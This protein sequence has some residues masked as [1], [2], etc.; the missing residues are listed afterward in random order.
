MMSAAAGGMSSGS[1]IR[2]SF[3]GAMSG[4]LGRVGKVGGDEQ[5]RMLAEGL[6]D[7]GDVHRLEAGVPLAGVT[8]V[9]GRDIAGHDASGS[10]L[11][12]SG[13]SRS[14]QERR[15][16]MPL[17]KQGT[18]ILVTYVVPGPSSSAAGPVQVR[19]ISTPRLPARAR[20]RRLPRGHVQ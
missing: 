17:S 9:T 2:R 8:S 6:D 12:G 10:G 16:W 1:P 19:P 18:E 20:P 3:T 7:F 15:R 5:F 13:G 4:C 14:I 11:S